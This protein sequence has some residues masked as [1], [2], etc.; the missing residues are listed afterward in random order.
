MAA[1]EGTTDG[2]TNRGVTARGSAIKT[3]HRQGLQLETVSLPDRFSWIPE[4]ALVAH[5]VADQAQLGMDT[6]TGTAGRTKEPRA[7]AAEICNP[8]ITE[9]A[10]RVTETIVVGTAGRGKLTETF[11]TTMAQP[12]SPETGLQAD[13]EPHNKV[14]GQAAE[15]AV[16]DKEPTTV[17]AT[18]PEAG[19]PTIRRPP[20]ITAMVVT[21]AGGEAEIT[22]TS[23]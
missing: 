4:A 2:S 17:V 7:T 11:L 20:A 15:T 1:V 22:L 9:L 12:Q 18:V 14:V 10:G 13:P 5:L 19:S 3:V 8:V 6:E 16:L 23:N 21:A